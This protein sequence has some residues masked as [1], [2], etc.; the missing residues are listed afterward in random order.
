MVMDLDVLAES[1]E[2]SRVSSPPPMDRPSPPPAFEGFNG[3]TMGAV[4]AKAVPN[5]DGVMD[6]GPEEGQIEKEVAPESEENKE[7]EEKE[8]EEKKEKDKVV[9]PEPDQPRKIG[10]LMKEL[11][12][13]VQQGAMEFSMD[14]FDF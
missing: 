6:L 1:G 11:K 4:P 8:K 2:S 5:G 7:K 10:N 13:D 12:Q 14:S 3:Y 9:E